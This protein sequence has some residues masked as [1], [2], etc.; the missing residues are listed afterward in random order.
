MKYAPPQLSEEVE[1]SEPTI[2]C[3]KAIVVADLIS[4]GENE[5][6]KYI[7]SK[8]ESDYLNYYKKLAS[9][10][11]WFLY[12]VPSGRKDGHSITLG[13]AFTLAAIFL[14]EGSYREPVR[15]KRNLLH[16]QRIVNLTDDDII[17]GY[18]NEIS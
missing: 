12:N 10:A 14:H 1:D 8:N 4:Y 7:I 5:I 13:K 2:I 3:A 6:A 11:S 16:Y 9:I 15:K 17:V 18:I